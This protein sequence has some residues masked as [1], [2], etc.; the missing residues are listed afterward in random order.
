MASKL[1][2]GRGKKSTKNKSTPTYTLFLE[3]LVF[4]M[5]AGIIN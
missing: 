4:E 1:L 2:D 3:P 5:S